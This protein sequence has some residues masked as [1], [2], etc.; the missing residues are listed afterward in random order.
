MP[1]NRNGFHVIQQGVSAM[2]KQVDKLYTSSQAREKLHGMHAT[3][4]KRLVESGKIQKV[5][6][7]GKTQGMYVKEDV[8]K[9][10]ETMNAFIEI[11]ST[12]P[13]EKIQ[14]IK[15]QD[16]DDIK[17][18]AQIARQHFGDLA[19]T[20][21]ERLE[22]FKRVP[23]ADYVL[24]Y[25]GVVVGYFSMQPVKPDALTDHILKPN[26]GGVRVDDLLPFTPYQALE[27]YVTGMG[28][29]LDIHNKIPN[30]AHGMLLI[31]GLS[32]ILIELAKGGVDIRKIWTKSRTV[33]GIKICRDLQFEELGFLDSE[34]ILF[35]L[36]LEASTF[37][38]FVR[39]RSVLKEQKS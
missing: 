27:C 32:S 9:F 15:A 3:S 12:T 18:S 37:P 20:A 5:V 30:R 6:P 26:G 10:A 19:Y 21:E 23:D 2:P 31:M 38:L 4:F 7:P 11:Y 35:K 17:A 33:S 1:Y 13:T 34:H 16:E 25:E 28:V 14:V 39:Y 22:F 36:D 29:K 8:D 24:K